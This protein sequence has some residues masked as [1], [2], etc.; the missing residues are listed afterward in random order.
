MQ[1]GKAI[2]ALSALGPRLS[3]ADIASFSVSSAQAQVSLHI[4]LAL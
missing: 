4:Q 2:L 1:V 3:V